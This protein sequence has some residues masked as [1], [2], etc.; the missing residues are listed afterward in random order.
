MKR[1]GIRAGSRRLIEAACRSASDSLRPA[2]R[3]CVSNFWVAVRLEKLESELR[4]RSRKGKLLAFGALVLTGRL[5][6]EEVGAASAPPNEQ[7]A[8]PGRA[9]A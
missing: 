2:W 7:Y 9:Q 6:K 8:R 3:N 1:R 5:L 4:P